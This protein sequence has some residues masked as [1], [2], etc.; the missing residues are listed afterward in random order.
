MEIGAVVPETGAAAVAGSGALAAPEVFVDLAVV[1]TEAPRL[2]A[3]VVL[4][5]EA[6]GELGPVAIGE[7]PPVSVAPIQERKARAGREETAVPA[8][9][10]VA[11]VPVAAVAQAV[12]AST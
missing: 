10:L 2:A 8:R 12:A 3:H 5:L 6:L 1:V 9:Q 4:A 11:S 7:Q